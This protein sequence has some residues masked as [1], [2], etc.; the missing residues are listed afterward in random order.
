MQGC[1]SCDDGTININSF[2]LTAILRLM[3][4]NDGEG[5]VELSIF[6]GGRKEGRI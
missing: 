3:L 2:D 4:L 6:D 5:L 1:C